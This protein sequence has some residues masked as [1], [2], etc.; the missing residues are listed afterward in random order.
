MLVGMIY[1][2]LSSTRKRCMHENQ[3][4]FRPSHSYNDQIFALRQ[5]FEQRHIFRKPTISIFLNLK[6]AFDPVYREIP[7]RRLSL[8][9]MSEKFIS[10][11]QFQ[12][13]NNQTR[14][15]AYAIFHPGSQSDLLFVRV[16]HFHLSFLNLS[17]G[18]P[19]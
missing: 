17:F 7:W 12:Y 11:I 1:R 19:Q 6:A 15:S 18:W 9:S 4:C 3:T 13:P 16:A 2:R 8:K 5:I 14:V 10:L